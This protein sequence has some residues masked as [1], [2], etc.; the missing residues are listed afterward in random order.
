M[1]RKLEFDTEENVDDIYIKFFDRIKESDPIQN[2]LSLCEEKFEAVYLEKVI[3]MFQSHCLLQNIHM[4]SRLPNFIREHLLQIIEEGGPEVWKTWRY[5][6]FFLDL[7]KALVESYVSEKD[8]CNFLCLALKDSFSPETV[9][10]I[11]KYLLKEL[12]P[13]LGKEAIDG[14]LKRLLKKD[15]SGLNFVEY[16]LYKS[17]SAQLIHLV[18]N[19]IKSLQSHELNN[20]NIPSLLQIFIAETEKSKEQIEKE[21]TLLATTEFPPLQMTEDLKQK[22]ESHL[23]HFREMSKQLKGAYYKYFDSPG[24]IDSHY[25]KD[26]ASIELMRAKVKGVTFITVDIEYAQVEEGMGFIANSLQICTIDSCFFVDALELKERARP[27]LAELLEDASILKIFHGCEADLETIYRSF[28]L[29]VRN[30]Y[31]TARAALELQDSKNMPGLNVLSEKHLSISINKEYQKSV[32]RVRPLPKPMLEYALTD[33]IILL[34]IFY[35]QWIE[36][37]SLEDPQ[38]M[39]EKVLAVSR[40]NI[41]VVKLSDLEIYFRDP[42][43]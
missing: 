32:W 28:S 39:M 37:Q 1:Q 29:V 25:I 27:V 8:D 26:E 3:N 20:I 36:M 22:F 12:D 23:K 34:P 7:D 41:K 10:G 30:I 21:K 38:Q 19:T 35:C 11:Y 40:N 18:E 17:R 24:T 14:K 43:K 4:S 5:W 9:E 15:K 6:L 16:S 42:L 31:D 33:A 13:Q 2:F